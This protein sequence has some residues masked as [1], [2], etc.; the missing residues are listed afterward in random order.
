M[1]YKIIPIMFVCLFLALSIVSAK[2]VD[3]LD[4]K[5]EKLTIKEDG[6]YNNQ[7]QLLKEKEK[8]EIWIDKKIKLKDGRNE[9]HIDSLIEEDT[10]IDIVLFYDIQPDSIDYVSHNGKYK[11]TFTYNDWLWKDKL[12]CGE[13]EYCGGYVTIPN[14][15]IE[16]GLGSNTFTDAIDGAT[17]ANDGV[18]V[19]LTETTDYTLNTAT[20]LFTI[21]NENYKWSGL[22]VSYNWNYDSNRRDSIDGL[23][24]NFTTGIDNVS[25]KFP[26]IF[27]IGI[28]VILFGVLFLLVRQ[29]GLIEMI[30]KGGGN[31]PL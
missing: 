14:V 21:V 29:T 31:S 10:T 20:G 22:N 8:A 18:L 26:T 16:Y 13:E 5:T 19:T 4:W 1:K 24:N 11:E 3:K 17:W 2:Q 6:I 7:D 9:Y 27:T 15:I 28:I 12:D 30:N 25:T 23:T